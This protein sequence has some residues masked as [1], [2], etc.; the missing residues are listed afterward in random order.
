MAANCRPCGTYVPFAWH[1]IQLA[2]C[3]L[4]FVL[5]LLAREHGSV[6]L[7]RATWPNISIEGIADTDVDTR[8]HMATVLLSA[9]DMDWTPCFAME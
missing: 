5:G 9:L 2:S 6:V 3:M 7:S 8:P 4:E 1:S